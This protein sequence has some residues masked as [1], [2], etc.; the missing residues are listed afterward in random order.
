MKI[1][2]RILLV[3]MA[4]CLGGFIGNVFSSHFV[5][6][7]SA[8]DVSD[9]AEITIR[10]KSHESTMTWFA[11]DF[12]CPVTDST[13]NRKLLAATENTLSAEVFDGKSLSIIDVA[14]ALSNLNN[15]LWTVD[16]ATEFVGSTITT[17]E[18]SEFIDTLKSDN[19]PLKQ[20]F[21][22]E[23]FNNFLNKKTVDTYEKKQVDAASGKTAYTLLW[24]YPEKANDTKAKITYKMAD[25][26]AVPADKV[27]ENPRIVTGVS[28]DTYTDTNHYLIPKIDGYEANA[29]EF[30][31]DNHGK[32]D[33]DG[34]QDIT[35]TYAK[36]SPVN[37]STGA[38]EP[39][40]VTS[41]PFKVYGKRGLYR[42]QNPDFNKSE[43]LQG[44]AKKSKT[45]APIFTV[46]KT[47]KNKAGLARYQ[48]SDGSY[49]TANPDYVAKLYW[50]G[51]HY[52][53]LYVTNPRGVNAH[54]TTTFTDKL[55]HY[56]QGSAVTVIKRVRKGQM[57]RY[58]LADGTYITGNKQW[59]SPNRPRLVTRV[60]AKTKVT[61]YRNTDLKRIHTHYAKNHLI[62][63]K[64][65]DDTN[66]DRSAKPGQKLYRVSGGYILA[67]TRDLKVIK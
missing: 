26:S 59:V 34:D 5:S 13:T 54:Q 3:T 12:I 43:R 10:I 21:D 37:H 7:A 45:Y 66:G 55:G 56:K 6:P 8:D 22:Q 65:W 64:G 19:L 29:N 51:T 41:D 9:D 38:S 18:W 36:P 17:D 42:Y 25:G 24:Y 16:Q 63:V 40:V 20:S 44:Y 52:Q 1:F 57:T 50:Q 32:L 27:P 30:T 23:N 11:A 28:G 33:A 53:T 35:I 15:N 61:V 39:D 2:K 14:V 58:Q 46:V 31:F 60:K 62:A 67:N 49:I 48:L 4:L 47:V